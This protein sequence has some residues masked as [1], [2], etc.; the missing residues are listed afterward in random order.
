VGYTPYTSHVHSYPQPYSPAELAFS[1]SNSIPAPSHIQTQYPSSSPEQTPPPSFDGAEEVLVGDFDAFDTD[2]SSSSSSSSPVASA[3]P[4]LSPA[5]FA[6]TTNAAIPAD[7]L[8]HPLHN[9]PDSI[10]I[11]NKRKASIGKITT[12]MSKMTFSSERR[13]FNPALTPKTREKK[14]RCLVRR[15]SLLARL[16]AY[17]FPYST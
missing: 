11:I 8:S 5:S 15:I 14:Y 13:R 7:I 12:K 16:E 10:N 2:F 1:A 3:P 9:E 17:F 6:A 4:G